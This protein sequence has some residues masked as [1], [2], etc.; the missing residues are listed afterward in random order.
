[1]SFPLRYSRLNPSPV[2]LRSYRYKS[3]IPCVR[4]VSVFGGRG[5]DGVLAVRGARIF[6]RGI[7][8]GFIY[9]VIR[10][11]VEEGLADVYQVTG[12]GDE[13]AETKG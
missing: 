1:M 2:N 9:L 8:R 5:E 10:A 11:I 7:G 3:H 4:A 6:V 13:S 12:V